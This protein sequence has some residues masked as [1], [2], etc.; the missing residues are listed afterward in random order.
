METTTGAIYKEHEVPELDEAYFWRSTIYF[1]I[2]R[3]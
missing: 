2:I 3:D 1:T